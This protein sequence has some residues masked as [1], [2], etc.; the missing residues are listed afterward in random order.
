[1]K[2]INP[3][4][5]ASSRRAEILDEARRLERRRFRPRVQQHDDEDKQHH[6]GAGV[7]D[8]LRRGDEFAAEQQVQHRERSH[9]ADQRKSA[10]DG[11][12]LHHQIDA[13]NDG[14]RGED[15]KEERSP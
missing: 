1:M 15:E 6:D 10:R 4:K 8:H 9:D 13:A 2:L 11:V 7:D 3:R 12:R 14:D 5:A